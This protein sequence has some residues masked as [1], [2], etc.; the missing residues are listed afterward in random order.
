MP[1]ADSAPHILVEDEPCDGATN[2]ARD[3]ALLEAAAAGETT[4]RVY[5]WA[6]PTLSLGHFQKTLP[7]N[8]PERLRNLP[9]VRRLSGGGAILHHH[10]WTY[11]VAVPRS[12]PLARRPETLYDAVHAALIAALAVQGVSA[13]LRGT[14]DRDADANFLC[15]SRGDPRDV[16]VAG[17]KIVG[18][19]QRRRRGAV[20]QHGSVLL[21]ASEFAPQ[22]P[23]LFDLLPDRFAPAEQDPRFAVPAFVAA[24]VGLLRGGR[25][26]AN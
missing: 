24:G 3:A 7:A 25:N 15:F 26:L 23:G 16:L 14:S 13:S 10:E 19:A 12:H 22:L 4:L 5:R 17:Q 20:L 21:R 9:T 11:A 1:P 6:V 2:M 8:L 18:S